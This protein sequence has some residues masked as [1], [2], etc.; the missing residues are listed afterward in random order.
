MRLK[1]RHLADNLV[2]LHEVA[3]AWQ[4]ESDILVVAVN[5]YACRTNT[6]EIEYLQILALGISDM[7]TIILERDGNSL[8]FAFNTLVRLHICNGRGIPKQEHREHY[9]QYLLHSNTFL[10]HSPTQN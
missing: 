1:Y 2:N 8:H 10:L 4:I 5:T 7:Q 9:H 3:S 6:C